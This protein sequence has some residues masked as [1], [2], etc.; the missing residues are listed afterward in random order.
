MT[1]LERF[2]VRGF[3]VAATTTPNAARNG[4][5]VLGSAFGSLTGLHELFLLLLVALQQRIR[6][7]GGSVG[8]QAVATPVCGR[9]RRHKPFRAPAVASGVAT[10][11]PQKSIAVRNRRSC[12][13]A[14][15][16]EREQS[17]HR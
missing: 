15:E 2:D 13:P 17:C 7:N 10:A 8:G 9:L 11:Y 1:C 14:T 4:G 6:R 16:T 3:S 12:L 5:S